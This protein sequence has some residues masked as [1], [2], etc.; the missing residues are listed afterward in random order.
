MNF[1]KLLSALAIAAMAVFISGCTTSP[2]VADSDVELKKISKER[3]KTLYDKD[4]ALFIDARPAKL[5]K[6]GTIM[7]SV[8]IPSNLPESKVGLLPQDKDAKIVSYCNGPKCHHSSKLAKKLVKRGYSN[9]VV[10]DGGYPEWKEA[11]YPQ[12]GLLRECEADSDGAYEPSRDQITKNGVTVYPGGVS[13]QVDQKWLAP[14]IN[15]GNLPE[16]TVLIDVRKADQYE[17]GHIKGAKN[18]TYSSEN[19]SLDESKLPKDKLSIFYCN[20]GLTSADAYNSL[21]D[22]AKKRALY[23]DATIK[24]DSGTCQLEANQD[25]SELL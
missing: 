14:M 7:G 1:T 16:G 21:S 11:E 15:E 5:F 17:E 12:M 20:T 25:L 8:N 24:C 9:V 10:Y 22:E 6:V 19:D 3:A 23:I 4:A 18:V 2:K 13:G